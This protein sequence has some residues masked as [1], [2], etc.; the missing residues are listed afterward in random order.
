[1]PVRYRVVVYRPA[2]IGDTTRDP[3]PEE[4]PLIQAFHRR[5]V[6]RHGQ[7]PLGV[8]DVDGLEPAVWFMEI[9]N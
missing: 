6:E 7:E 8:H 1:M 3:T 5:F 4:L 2:P 9:W